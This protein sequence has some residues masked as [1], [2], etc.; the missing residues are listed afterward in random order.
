MEQTQTVEV[1][2]TAD[3]VAVMLG[4]RLTFA[5]IC[6][7]LEVAYPSKIFFRKVVRSRIVNLKTSKNARIHSEKESETNKTYWM[8][9][10]VEPCYFRRDSLTRGGAPR[11]DPKQPYIRPRPQFSAPEQEA[12]RLARLFDLFL[13]NARS[14]RNVQTI[15]IRSIGSISRF[16]CTNSSRGRWWSTLGNG[17][18]WWV[19]ANNVSG[20]VSGRCQSVPQN[21]ARPVAV[22]H[23]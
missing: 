2:T 6:A 20:F 5:E 18:G 17:H 9:V 14:V 22:I 23:E 12:C 19:S 11:K 13:R 1:V 7:A 8:L 4:K 16:H 3:I 10:S 21:A 15:E